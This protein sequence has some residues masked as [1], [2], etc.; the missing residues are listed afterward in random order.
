M[1]LDSGKAAGHEMHHPRIL[2][3]VVA[4][5]GGSMM[6]GDIQVADRVDVHG[7]GIGDRA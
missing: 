4:V 3:A 1:H 6:V 5:K 7:D 2:R